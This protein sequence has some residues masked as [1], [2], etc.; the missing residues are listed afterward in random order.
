M[1][2]II[3]KKIENKNKNDINTYIEILAFITWK[4]LKE[5]KF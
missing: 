4:G 5:F 2:I 3:K 1:K